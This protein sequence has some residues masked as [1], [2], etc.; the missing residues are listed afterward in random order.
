MVIMKNTDNIEQ[1][2][3]YS[4]TNTI[5]IFIGKQTING[6]QTTATGRGR[7]EAFLIMIYNW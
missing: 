5:V 3:F 4:I 1:K 7:G 6:L 2:H